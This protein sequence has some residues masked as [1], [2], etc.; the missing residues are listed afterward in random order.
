MKKISL[1]LLAALFSLSVYSQSSEIKLHP[2][3]IGL[4]VGDHFFMGPLDQNH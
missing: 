4:S 2:W 1:F 3:S